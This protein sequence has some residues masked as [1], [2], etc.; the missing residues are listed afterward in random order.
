MSSYNQTLNLSDTVTDE[1]RRMEMNQIPSMEA[2]FGQ[3]HSLFD[4][5]PTSP[6]SVT[7]T[8]SNGDIITDSNDDDIQAAFQTAQLGRS[9]N[10]S[11][12]PKHDKAQHH[13]ACC[14]KHRRVGRRIWADP[15]NPFRSLCESPLEFLTLVIVA[16]GLH[17]SF[18]FKHIQNKTKPDQDQT[19]Q[20]APH[21]SQY[22]PVLQPPPA[23][24]AG[25][26]MTKQAPSQASPPEQVTDP[27]LLHSKDI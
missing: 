27:K 14:C 20:A 17:L 8:D 13:A 24:P 12:S 7:Y 9:I 18:P 3:I 21:F 4:I 5:H 22:P 19:D 6:L 1:T 15:F 23:P 16:M 10:F 11:V 2:L 25:M 26:A